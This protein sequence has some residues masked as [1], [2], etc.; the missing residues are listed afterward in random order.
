MAPLDWFFVVVLLGST[1]LGAWRGLVYEVLSASG[2]VAAFF[3]AQWLAEDVGLRLPWHSENETLRYLVGF[4]VVFVAAVFAAGLLA[5]CVKKLIDTVGLRPADRSLGALF[6]AVRGIVLLLAVAV[7]GGVTPMH[8][9]F[10]WQ[11]SQGAQWLEVALHGLR[12]LLP[13]EFGKHLPV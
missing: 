1:L 9:A 11:E 4:L 2:W 13:E 12:P 7:V 6:G 3:A 5:W 10:W 8:E